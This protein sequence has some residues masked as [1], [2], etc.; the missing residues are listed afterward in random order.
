MDSSS[1]K[2]KAFERI[3]DSVDRTEVVDL[4]ER[5]IR[6]DS[7]ISGDQEKGVVDE[8]VEFARTH[9]LDYEICP[10]ID[11]RSNLLI[12]V[13]GTEPSAQTI[14]YCGHMDVVPP[15]HISH[16]DSD[17][18]NPVI[19]DG[20]LYGRGSVDMKGSIAAA[21]CAV[22]ALSRA[23]IHLEGSILFAFV[24]DE[25]TQ[26]RGMKAFL[27]HKS[28]RSIGACVLGEPSNLEIHIGHKG[29]MGFWITFFGKRA[30]AA[31]PEQGINALSY[32][33]K[34]VQVVEQYQSDVL[35]PR[36]HPHLGCPTL[37]V[38][39]IRAG[40]ELN[41]IP[42]RA[43]MRLDRRFLST[44]ETEDVISE[45]ENLLGEFLMLYPECKAEMKITTV[46]PPAFLDRH[47]ELV[48][49]VSKAI[50]PD[51]PDKVPVGTFLAGSEMGMIMD[52]LQIPAL[53]F[54]PGDLSKAHRSNESI[55][56]EQL[57]RGTELYA[58]IFYE[59][60]GHGV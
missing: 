54:G 40:L 12:Y 39:M 31:L 23:N 4:L 25:E 37:T 51:F 47:N 18:F 60:C 17:P 15:G 29:V 2:K 59:Y 33:A 8:L 52:G 57:Y 3:S 49:L 20:R 41:S 38:T 16:W 34:F 22:T 53:I 45:M 55:D 21:L 58:R 44:E 13:H 43:E 26:N 9:A 10:V 1:R 7:S 50:N 35:S 28:S 48:D 14:M 19:V 56:L 11:D 27:E 32:C 6:H 30:H 42:E 5:L 24:I 36:I 46:C